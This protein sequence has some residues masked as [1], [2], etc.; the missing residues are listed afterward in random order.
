MANEKNNINELVSVDDDDDPTAELEVLTLGAMSDAA[1]D[2]LE[3]DAHTFNVDDKIT[4]SGDRNVAISDLE[5]D[6]QSRS[7]T[8]NRLQ[9]DIEQLRSKWL[10]LEAEIQAREEQTRKLNRELDVV[11]KMLQRKEALLKK[12]DQVIKT[13]K[14]EIREQ[15]DHY[16]SLQTAHDQLEQQIADEM[17]VAAE[18]KETLG[19]ANARIDELETEVDILRD[20]QQRAIEKDEQS[21]RKL[22]EQQQAL[23]VSQETLTELETYID[24]RATRWD[25][26]QAAIRQLQQDGEYLRKEL[27]A[28]RADVETRDDS[29]RVLQQDNEA[30]HRQ[31]E[32]ASNAEVEQTQRLLS[33][34]AG[35]IASDV[36]LI[37]EL[38]T[39]I[40]RNEAYAD[41]LRQQLQD[42]I[43]EAA[44]VK[45]IHDAMQKAVDRSTVVIDELQLELAEQHQTTSDLRQ[46]LQDRTEETTNFKNSH[47]TMQKALDDATAAADELRQELAEQQQASAA[48]QERLDTIEQRHEEELR[49]VRFE[50]GEAQNTISEHESINEQLTS[51]LIDTRGF[52]IQLEN[53]ISQ[54]EEKHQK[55]IEGLEQQIRAL[56]GQIEDY[57]QKLS[58]KSEAINCLLTELAKK[59]EQVESIGQIEKVIHEIDNRMSQRIDDRPGGDRITRVL[60]GNIDGQVLRFPLFKNRLTIGRT[61]QND[62]QLSGTYVSRRHA[63]VVTEGDTARIVDWGSKN[64]VFV[65]S[66]KVSEHVLQ[67]GDIVSIG[68][69]KFRYEERPK[70]DA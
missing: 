52:R 40:E 7:E 43:E 54:S 13:L 4:A 2:D 39:R 66:A 35:Q 61:P 59:T 36:V 10:G 57:E 69:A 25:T 15:E 26:Q 70:R 27:A 60:I 24:A 51:D 1:A 63:L 17:L 9:F 19:T 28:A 8:I 29:I 23:Q 21:E 20:A 48:L 37:A 32:A 50:L 31:M 30:L 16:L 3:S 18:L 44:N 68:T 33:E 41:S 64:G 12:R 14:S 58:T 45:N 5:S 11:S 38:R 42:R 62:I 46:Q 53:M 47:S 56:T 49:T 65:N 67:S 55:Q 6:L 34:Q 22:T